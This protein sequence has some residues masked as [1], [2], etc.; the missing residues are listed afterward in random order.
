MG[1]ISREH[2][3]LDVP[4]NVPGKTGVAPENRSLFREKINSDYNNFVARALEVVDGSSWKQQLRVKSAGNFFARGSD[5][6]GVLLRF[7][8]Y[9]ALMP[10][11]NCP[12]QR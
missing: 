5:T 12:P 10:I 2:S 7:N 8:A 11:N 9:V 1:W 4:D 3:T 6:G